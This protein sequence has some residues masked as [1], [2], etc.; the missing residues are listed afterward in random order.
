MA[1]KFHGWHKVAAHKAKPP[2]PREH[3]KLD[4][5]QRSALSKNLASAIAH[6]DVGHLA[7]ANH[8]AANLVRLMRQLGILTDD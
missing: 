3:P 8:S 7:A 1:A 4:H 6:H 2:Q 5:A